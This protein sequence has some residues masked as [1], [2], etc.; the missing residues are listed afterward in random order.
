MSNKVI[1]NNKIFI[2]FALLTILD[3]L[4]EV[5]HRILFFGLQEMRVDSHR[6]SYSRHLLL[7]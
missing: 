1:A 4:L 3:Q 5:A 7:A 2:A 6:D